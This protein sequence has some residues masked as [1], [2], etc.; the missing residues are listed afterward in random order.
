MSAARAHSDALP[1]PS[2][3]QT[4]TMA[5]P[6]TPAPESTTRGGPLV[7]VCGLQ[8]GAG[9]S[10]LA[11]LLATSA[12]T[13][14]QEGR[15]VLIEAP[16]ATGDQAVL[17]DAR[18]TVSLAELAA[19][20]AAGRS[21]RRFWGRAGAL[22][23]I[24]TDPQP[25]PQATTGRELV[26]VLNA[27]RGEHA[28]GVVDAGTV[29]AP[30][31]TTVLAAASHV[32]WVLRLEPGAV[33]RARA[34]LASRLVPALGARQILTVRGAVARERFGGQGPALR[35]LAADHSARLVLMPDLATRQT[36]PNPT[37]AR[38][39]RLTSTLD[40]WLAEAWAA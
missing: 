9:A 35:Q 23:V 30:H 6:A 24:A 20:V 4:P 13:R 2:P 26:D 3:A 28:L 40:R 27:A 17:T 15:V 39:R 36:R 31:A 8:G 38:A 21:P 16:G 32:I 5:V 12:A 37:S 33:A 22:R 7:A 1:T 14:D 25:T 10:T 29:R 34:L 19:Q 11:N 18:S